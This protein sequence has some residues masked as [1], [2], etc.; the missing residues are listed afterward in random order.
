MLNLWIYSIN[1]AA[2]FIVQQIDAVV[3]NL[4]KTKH[5][6]LINKEFLKNSE[7]TGLQTKTLKDE[8]ITIFNELNL[9]V[10]SL[11]DDNQKDEASGIIQLY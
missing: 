10:S 7:T 9:L 8:I 11:E 6:P 5:I 3:L 4:I 1:D 2:T